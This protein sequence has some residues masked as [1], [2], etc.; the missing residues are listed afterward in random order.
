MTD[1]SGPWKA[2]RDI[3]GVVAP[4][5]ATALGGPLAGQAAQ[6]V[7]KALGLAPDATPEQVTAGLQSATPEQLLQLKK[8]DQEFA[9]AM[10]ELDIA[11]DRLAYEDRQSARARDVQTND[12]TTHILAGVAVVSTF[13][14]VI[15]I[16]TGYAKVQGE[17]AASVVGIILASYKDVFGFYFGSSMGSKQKTIEM[18]RSQA[19]TQS[20]R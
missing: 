8:Q 4:T 14:I 16:L 6:F 12:R 1:M 18:V 3:L 17:F 13:A 7:V 9:R 10:R 2:A 15:L 5:L 20:T 11:E 19:G